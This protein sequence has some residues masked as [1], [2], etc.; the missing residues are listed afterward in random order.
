MGKTAAASKEK[1]SREELWVGFLIFNCYET[2]AGLFGV[3]HFHVYCVIRVPY[4]NLEN[5]MWDSSSVANEFS[6]DSLFTY[7]YDKVDKQTS[8]S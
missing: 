7:F 4:R 5:E 3:Y 1:S 2:Q 8:C 6:I